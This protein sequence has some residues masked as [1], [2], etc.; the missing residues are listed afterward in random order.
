MRPKVRNASTKAVPDV[1]EHADGYLEVRAP[2]DSLQDVSKLDTV[3]MVAALVRD[4]DATRLLFICEDSNP[5]PEGV[6]A[7]AYGD[8]LA[9]KL[10]GV[11]TAIAVVARPIEYFEDFA[12]HIAQ[13]SGMDLRYFTDI[14]AA[15]RWLVDAGGANVRHQSKTLSGEST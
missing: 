5:S 14:E 10:V 12:A 15:R 7:Y 13:K 4:R 1:S 9:R 8:A 11:R 2:P 3:E 6:A